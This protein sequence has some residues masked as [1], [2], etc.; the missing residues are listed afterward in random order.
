MSVIDYVP[1]DESA[2]PSSD[3][4]YHGE[5]PPEPTAWLIK[6]VLPQT[7]A[8]LISGQWG[9]YKTTVAL[10]LAVST[11]TGVPFADRYVVKRRGGV[12]CFAPE[13]ANGLASR[14][15]AIA[16]QRGHSGTLPFAWK[17]DCPPLMA[18]DALTTLTNEVTQAAEHFKSNSA[19]HSRWS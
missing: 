4:R 6:N 11:M 10:E 17:A 19:S 18:K 8:G 16:T 9:S 5:A 15:S 1:E 14:L 3:W 2:A 12:V 13:G 7:G